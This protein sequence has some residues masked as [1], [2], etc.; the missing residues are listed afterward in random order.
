[1]T[2]SLEGLLMVLGEVVLLQDGSHL[3]CALRTRYSDSVDV[4]SLFR[5]T[6]RASNELSESTNVYGKWSSP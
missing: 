4:N 1:M 3:M 2:V 5:F 6:I